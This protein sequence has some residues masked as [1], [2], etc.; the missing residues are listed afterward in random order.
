VSRFGLFTLWVLANVVGALAMGAQMCRSSDSWLLAGVTFGVPQALALRGFRWA[1]WGWAP[2]A[3]IVTPPSMYLS[4]ICGAS[5]L[6]ATQHSDLPR[7][8]GARLTDWA[9]IVLGAAP[10]WF[11]VA[12]SQALLVWIAGVRRAWLWVP[13][14]LV[15]GVGLDPLGFASM[16]G[17]R[18]LVPGVSGCAA[19]QITGGLLGCALAGAFYGTVTGVALQHLRNTSVART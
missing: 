19:L 18:E 10:G 3:A 1:P 11:G 15:G 6:Q 9:A 2:V 12:I 8:L 14:V 17:S 13:A 16:V 4:A 5:L 7:I